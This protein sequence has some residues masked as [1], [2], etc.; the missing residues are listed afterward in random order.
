[1][2]ERYSL[3]PSQK[4]SRTKKLIGFYGKEAVST[5]FAKHY[6]KQPFQR[7]AKKFMSRTIKDGMRVLDV[8]CGTGH[9][10]AGLPDSIEVVGVDI[11]PEMVE[12]AK[13]ARP[14][15]IYFAHDFHDPVPE[16]TGQ[17][18]VV[19]ANGCFDLCYNIEK[20][21]RSLS[22][23]LKK[24]KLFYFTV[25]ERRAGVTNH[26]EREKRA[27][28]MMNLWNFQ[29]VTHA[30]E[31]AGLFPVSYH[32]GTGWKSRSLGVDFNYGYWVVAASG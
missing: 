23:T 2:K 11:T 30:L 20:A 32:Y 1:M 14:S 7:R 6:A 17:F 22:L 8:G 19:I 10:T 5:D 16:N 28:V 25:L 12:K 9:L 29:E 18:D 31:L 4:Q 24:A 13:E 15:A 26:E 21:V 3:T 27:S